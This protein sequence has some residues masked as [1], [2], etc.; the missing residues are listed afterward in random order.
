MN[1][2]QR[3]PFRSEG[4]AFRLLMTVVLAGAVVVAVTLLTRPLIGAL[5]GLL[6]V[7][8]AL[9][10]VWGWGRAWFADRPASSDAEVERPEKERR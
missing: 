5:L 8:V 9:W 3:N 7:A 4:D 10:R 1:E 2:P 6:L